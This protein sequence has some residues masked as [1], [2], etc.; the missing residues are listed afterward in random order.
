MTAPFDPAK[1]AE[2]EALNKE[3]DALAALKPGLEKAQPAETVAGLI[4]SSINAQ[5]DPMSMAS[6]W[7]P[8]GGGCCVVV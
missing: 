1:V 7:A 4:V 2:I 6:E 3:R 8:K 5:E